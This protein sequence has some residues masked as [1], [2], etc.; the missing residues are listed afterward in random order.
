MKTFTLE[1]QVTISVYTIVEAETLD[2]AIQIAS[3][4]SIESSDWGNPSQDKEYWVSAEYDGDVF[5]I[6]DIS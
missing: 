1:G 5:E 4:R 2:E 3:E 6:N